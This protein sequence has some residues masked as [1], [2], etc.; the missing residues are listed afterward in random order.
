MD[1]L[2]LDLNITRL[3]CK[4]LRVIFLLSKIAI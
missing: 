2:R 3:E 1:E 4:A